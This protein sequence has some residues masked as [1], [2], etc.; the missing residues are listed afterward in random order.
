MVK[1]RPQV[2]IDIYIYN[3]HTKVKLIALAFLA[4]REAKYYARIF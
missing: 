2:K 4:T 3:T 1:F